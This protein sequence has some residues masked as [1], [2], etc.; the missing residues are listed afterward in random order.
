[1]TAR[2]LTLADVSEILN[3]SM[4]ATRSL[5]TTGELPAIQIGG[6]R[7]WRVEREELEKFIDR[8]Y[9]QTRQRIQRNEE[10]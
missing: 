6:K 2:F 1:M 4:S 7:Q 5:V 3:L 9:A 10:L 8:Q